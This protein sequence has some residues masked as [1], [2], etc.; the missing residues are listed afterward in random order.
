MGVDVTVEKKIARPRAQV[1]S[2]AMDAG[3]DTSWI[4]GISEAT[5]LTDPPARVGTQVARVAHFLGK[6]IEY[7]NEVEVYEPGALMVMR[8]IKGPFPMHI[9]YSFDETEGATLA[10]IRV[11]GDARGFYRMAGP[12]LSTMVR[13]SIGRDIANL[14]NVLEKRG[15]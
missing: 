6:R 7:V 1:A 9:T 11:E 13:R 3:N 14:K 15:A 8:S 10:R 5:M 2:Y 12:M 4:A